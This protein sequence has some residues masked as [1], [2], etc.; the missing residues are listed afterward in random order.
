MFLIGWATALA[1]DGIRPP[2]WKEERMA[3][4]DA[5]AHAVPA[6]RFE[7]LKGLVGMGG[8]VKM[9]DDESAV[10]RRAQAEILSTPG[11][12]QYYQE[13]M[14]TLMATIRAQP[15]PE[16]KMALY[17]NQEEGFEDLPRLGYDIRDAI[18]SLQTLKYLPSAES[19][20]ALAHFLDDPEGRDG[21]TI[22]GTT[23]ENGIE[24]VSIS[25]QVATMLDQIGI[26]NPPKIYSPKTRWESVDAWKDWWNEVKAGKRTYRFK[27][28]PIEYGPDGPVAAQ[29]VTRP[30]HDSAKTGP[31]QSSSQEVIRTS[32][33]AK[34]LW[35]IIGS[36]LLLLIAGWKI[37]SSRR[38]I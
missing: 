21:K 27:G 10:W 23:S 30:G 12:G 38:S 26:E 9:D 11:H 25:C 5:A 7:L 13:K 29:T 35:I 31:L 17:A 22:V 16:K 32:D 14:A 37:F 20:A 4:I 18:W 19:V 33:F 2:G 28:S 1:A 34:T 36:A 8:N 6:A 24:S 15:D 3:Q